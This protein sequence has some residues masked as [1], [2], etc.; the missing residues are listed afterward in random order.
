MVLLGVTLNLG[1]VE[2]VVL[3]LKTIR[4]VTLA[5]ALTAP[6]ISNG[7]TVAVNFGVNFGVLGVLGVTVFFTTGASEALVS[8]K[9]YHTTKEFVLIFYELYTNSLSVSSVFVYGV[10][11]DMTPAF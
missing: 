3:P 10:M 11:N 8:W 5:E 4:G 7:V 1:P 2:G 6:E 9:N